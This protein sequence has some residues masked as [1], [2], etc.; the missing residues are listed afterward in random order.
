MSCSRYSFLYCR[1]GLD[2]ARMKRQCKW[3]IWY[4]LA[5]NFAPGVGPCAEIVEFLLRVTARPQFLAL[6][7]RVPTGACPG[8]Y[9]MN[10]SDREQLLFSPYSADSNI[11]TCDCLH[12]CKS[13]SMQLP[14]TCVRV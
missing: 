8:Q 5:A 7:L 14:A 1:A 12:L 3:S 4:P 13:S 2:E 9:G 11:H 10:A 6:E